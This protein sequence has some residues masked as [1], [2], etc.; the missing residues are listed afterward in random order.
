M[1]VEFC[2][3]VWP[4]KLA[5]CPSP[6]YPAEP[7]GEVGLT[8][9]SCQRTNPLARDGAHFKAEA[10]LFPPFA[11]CLNLPSY[12]VRPVSGFAG[13]VTQE[14]ELFQ[15]RVVRAWRFG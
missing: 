10:L 7:K 11:P 4:S 3:A 6:Q 12:W 14:T 5:K 9:A 1:C 15:L 8:S 13:D 2:K